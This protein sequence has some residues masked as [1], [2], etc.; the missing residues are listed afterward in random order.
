MYRRFI[1][2]VSTVYRCADLAEDDLRRCLL[3]LGGFYRLL[4]GVDA[5][6]AVQQDRHAADENDDRRQNAQ[7][8]EKTI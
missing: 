1:N 4:W 7:L 6:T 5:L 8:C 2:D 3:S